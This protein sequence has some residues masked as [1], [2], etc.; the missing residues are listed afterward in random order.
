[1]IY[2][3]EDVPIKFSCLQLENCKIFTVWHRQIISDGLM[4]NVLMGG[5][6]TVNFSTI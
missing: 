1:V 2:D 4:I 6:M 5:Q 3:E